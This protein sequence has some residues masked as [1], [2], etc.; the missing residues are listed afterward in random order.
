M[1]KYKKSLK[2]QSALIAAGVLCLIAVQILAA[3]RVF[4]PVVSDEHWAE[5]Y[6][7]FIAGAALG[8]TLLLLIGFI[9][10]QRALRSEAELKKLYAKEHDERRIQICYNAQSGAYRVCTL[11]LLVAI[12]VT[13]YF[14]VTVSLTCLI[15]VLVQSVT[16]VLFKLYWHKRL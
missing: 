1:E 9:K 16:A 13:G 6:A 8:V 3:F 14:N 10:N 4:T 7:G 11:A 15:I 2:L 12:I 5:L